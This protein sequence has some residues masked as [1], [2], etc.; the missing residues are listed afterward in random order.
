MPGTNELMVMVQCWSR[1]LCTCTHLPNPTRLHDPYNSVSKTITDSYNDTILYNAFEVYTLK[2]LK[3]PP[4]GFLGTIWEIARE[5]KAIQ[6]IDWNHTLQQAR[7]LHVGRVGNCFTW[8]KQKFNFHTSL[9]WCWKF[10]RYS[11]PHFSF[12]ESSGLLVPEFATGPGITCIAFKKISIDHM[13]FISIISYFQNCMLFVV[14][15]QLI[16]VSI[17]ELWLGLLHA[18]IY[19]LCAYTVKNPI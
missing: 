4:R 6:Q 19:M 10:F 16:T 11:G 8:I 12:H 15:L 2:W 7:W 5:A 18:C 1:L 13:L 9:A 3:T 17:C 14:Y